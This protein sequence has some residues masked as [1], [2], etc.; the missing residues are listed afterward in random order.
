LP[1]PKEEVSLFKN[2][3]INNFGKIKRLILAFYEEP[4]PE[5]LQDIR[6]QRANMMITKVPF[7][8]HNKEYRGH[9]SG[10][11][12]FDE[13]DLEDQLKEIERTDHCGFIYDSPWK[14]I[15]ALVKQEAEKFVNKIVPS[16]EEKR[17]IDIKNLSQI[18]NKTN[19]II[20]DYCPEI[21][22]GG[23]VVP[24]IP[25]KPKL[26]LR[27]K[28]LS[29]NKREPKFGD[30]LKPSCII[31]NELSEDKKIVLSVEIK[32]SG[33]KVFEEEYKLKITTGQQ[34]TIKLSEIK[35]DKDNFQKG[36]HILRVTIKEDRSD[37]DTKSTSF[38]LETKRE[39]IKRGFIKKV[40]FYHNP[41]EPVR[42]RFGE[43]GIIKLNTGHKD[44][45]NIWNTFLKNPNVLNKQ[46]GFYIIKICLDEAINELLKIKL[47]GN[48][49]VELDD[50]VQEIKDTRDKM[51]QDVYG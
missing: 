30:I 14:E 18:I 48:Q 33:V 20:N 16:K 43:K 50:L 42:Y 4:I 35:L 7:E 28:Y 39:P 21:I 10:Y 12:E 6:I 9:F 37:V 45:E 5:T 2:K 8:I 44:F 27:I 19:Q 41:D 25:P 46:M 31:L 26:P 34:R 36:K 40:E 13:K 11:I 29:I 24:P 17:A 3:S 51:Y 22:G 15:K 47:R 1:S 49:D 23:T 38:Y 32:R